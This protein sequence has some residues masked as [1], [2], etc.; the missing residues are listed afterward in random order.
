LREAIDARG[1]SRLGQ[2]MPGHVQLIEIGGCNGNRY[3]FSRIRRC[4][5]R[6]QS[7]SLMLWRLS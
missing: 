4:L 3:P 5:S 2:R 1:E 6:C 7:R